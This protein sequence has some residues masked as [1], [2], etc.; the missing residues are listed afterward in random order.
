ML[1]LKSFSY[2]LFKAIANELTM[3]SYGTQ[4]ADFIS[5]LSSFDEICNKGNIEPTILIKHLDRWLPD[6]I[7]SQNVSEEISVFFV[8]NALKT[9]C[10]LGKHCIECLKEYLDSLDK[11]KWIE[12]FKKPNSYEFKILQIISEY[13]IPQNAVEAIRDVL[14]QIANERLSIPDKSLW[15][16]LVQKIKSQNRSLQGTFNGIRDSFCRGDNM[17]P[18]L[19]EFFSDWLF[20]Y[21]NLSGQASALRTIFTSAVINDDECLQIIID[22]KQRMPDIIAVAETGEAQ[23]FKDIIQNKLKDNNSNEFVEFAKLI[24]VELKKEENESNSE[25]EVS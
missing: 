18:E 17:T 20:K 13:K 9:D 24:G 7:T 11:D 16:E 19:F 8:E 4:R 23:D 2:P 10:N 5:V 14:K 12:V 15:N 1:A 22:N 21:S 25:T 6:E 3:N